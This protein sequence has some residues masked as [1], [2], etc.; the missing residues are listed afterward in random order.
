MV[1]IAAPSAAVTWAVGDTISFSGSARTSAGA[2]PAGVRAALVAE[3]A[4]LLARRRERLPHARDPGLRR[5][6]VGALRRARPRVP[7]APAALADRDRRRR[8]EHD[9]DDAAEPEDRERHAGSVPPGL[10]LSFASETL[11]TP[12]TRTVIARS[13]TSVSAPS[14]QVLG[15]AGYLWGAWS[16]GLGQTHAVTAPAS[17]AATFT[18]TYAGTAA[19]DAAL[20]GTDQV[21]PHVSTRAARHRRGLPRASP[22]GPV[23]RAPCGCTSTRTARRASSCWRSTAR[24][25]GRSRPRCWR[26]AATP[27][28]WRA[29]GTRSSSRAGVPLV[30]GQPYWIGLLNPLGSDGPLRWRDRAGDV[31]TAERVSLSTTLTALPASWQSSASWWDG[32]LSASVWGI[33]DGRARAHPRRPRRPRRRRRR[34]TPTPTAT[35]QPTTSPAPTATPPAEPPRP[36]GARAGPV[37]AWGFDDR[38]RAHRR[39]AQRRRPLRPRAR[40]QRPSVAR[41]AR[42]A[43]TPA[44]SR[45]RPGC[46]RT[47][48]RGHDRRSR[49]APGR[50][51][52]SRSPSAAARRAAR[53]SSG[54]W[55][56]L[57]RDLR[58]R[59]DPP[60]RR[61]PARR[62]AR[63][64]GA[65]GG[66][67]T[68]RL[69]RRLPRPPRRTA[70]LRPRADA[71]RRSARTWATPSN[72]EP[73]TC[74]KVQ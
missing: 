49:A 20:G 71:R 31:G 11:A 16:D 67:R 34:P 39:P 14:P 25:S 54:R 23:S 26:R 29:A 42:P 40:L 73:R 19:S 51:P 22:T 38:A 15:V 3:P 72:P 52:R 37:A 48:A 74:T 45:S 50:C 21:G 35:A 60:L 64:F 58:R 53:S 36:A 63:V 13:V 44:R 24:A 17:G 56:H 1:T 27:T 69:G 61:R 47:A 70:D 10:Q 43:S 66:S 12:F 9:R 62:H 55:T 28:R 8:P 7:V 18:A 4:P 2:T 6:R 68:L 41:D 65:L 30:A 5:R 33:P 59:D 57:A 32:P 46:A